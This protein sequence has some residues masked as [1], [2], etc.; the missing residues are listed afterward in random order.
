MDE[1]ADIANTETPDAAEPVPASPEQAAQSLVIA[2]AHFH[3]AVAMLI[4]AAQA[5]D[6]RPE[7]APELAHTAL[8]LLLDG[9]DAL[10]HAEAHNLACAGTA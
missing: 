3:E 10:G 1:L 5:T 8:R 7:S 2:R 4:C 6:Q 9:L